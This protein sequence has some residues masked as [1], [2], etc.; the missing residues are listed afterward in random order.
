MEPVHLRLLGPLVVTVDGVRIDVPG[1]GER[2]LL[3]LLALDAGR[4]VAVQ[5][6]V[7]SLWEDAMPADPTNALQLRV[8]KLRRS[9]GQL[10]VTD[11]SGYR[12]DLPATSIDVHR[13]R[14]LV[15]R[16]RPREALALWQG[17]PLAEFAGSR[18]ADV[19]VTAL[20]QEQVHAITDRIDADLAQGRHRELVGELQRLVEEHPANERLW[21]QL[22]LAQYRC[23]RQATALATF[24]R[25]RDVLADQFGLDPGPRLAQ[26]EGAVLR[27]DPSLAPPEVSPARTPAPLGRLVGRAGELSRVLSA[28][29]THRLVTVVGTGGVGK[30]RLAV[31]AA[32]EVAAAHDDGAVVVHLG[33]VT[34]PT[35]VAAAVAAAAGTDPRGGSDDRDLLAAWFQR[36]D[37]V[38]VLDGCE[39]VIAAT[40]DLVGDLLAAAP[41]LSVL[42]TSRVSLGIA[43]GTDVSLG[44]LSR[45]A[46]V[47]LFLERASEV[48]GGAGALDGQD[49]GG[50]AV[51]TVVDRVDRLP[52]AIELAAAWTR[53]LPVEEI[54]RRLDAD[55]ALL[56]HA[57]G[58]DGARRPLHDVV[59]RSLDLLSTPE[60]ALF[61]RL[62]VLVGSWSLEDAEVVCGDGAGDRTVVVLARLVEQS[63]VVARDGRYR[64]LAPLAEVAVARLGA[65]GEES[66][67]RQAH[68]TH[69]L[70]LARVA[71]DRL[72][73]REQARWLAR[74]RA[75]EANMAAALA[76]ARQQA[77]VGT[78]ELLL[79]AAGLGWFWFL[80]RHGDGRRELTAALAAADHGDGAA[81]SARGRALQAQSIVLRPGGCIVHPDDHAHELALASHDLLASVGDERRALLSAV[82]CDVQAVGGVGT[83]A[84]L[85]R[86]AAAA[87]RFSAWGDAWGAAMA[88]FV[89]MEIHVQQG[90]IDDAVL[91]GERARGRF[92]QVTD[93]WGTSSVALHLAHGLRLAGRI[94][95]ATALLEVARDEA[96][97]AGIR[98]TLCGIQVDLARIGL[99][100]GD[101]AATR[102]AVDRV[103]SL[104]EDLGNRMLVGMAEVVEATLQL[105]RDRGDQARRL[106]RAA[107]ARF[108][109]EGVP[110]GLAEALSLC[111]R[112][113]V[114]RGDLG[115]AER[116]A[117]RS[118][119]LSRSMHDRG[120]EA[121]ALETLALAAASRGACTDA[122]TALG[123]AASVRREGGR[124]ACRTEQ[125][126]ADRAAT[127]ARRVLGDQR[128]DALVAAA[129]ATTS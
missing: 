116:H 37:C 89:A 115:A 121:Q 26:L 112:D 27:Q 67:V 80:G 40:A 43:G 78:D 56:D 51:A 109:A 111:A 8:S 108:E 104:A 123:R 126:V 107:I 23:E 122:A 69:F 98:N 61:R 44:P 76:W 4:R 79:A 110:G 17:P 119:D 53:S 45:S 41:R 15:A 59:A 95:H 87:R 9:V 128:F 72:R 54:A 29:A 5:H 114:D 125:V 91:V 118:L 75:S 25:A 93:A 90:D 32:G 73:G 22:M 46:A 33:D 58:P 124:P 103:R 101:A 60:E 70:G 50:P 129:G 21:A 2:A 52:L 117:R 77:G 16:R 18:W 14:E 64:I 85:E 97:G 120:L 48:A 1:R 38:L 55:L 94:D 81:A 68:A 66:M 35:R 113:E 99:H 86:L 7:E 30:T 88:D 19:E 92:E 49:E 11:P 100:R 106:L 24:Q 74:L 82:M 127:L 84:A 47:Q 65:A 12:L 13:F 36:R 71:E 83:T 3:S 31:A 62:G 42:A 105:E 96:E 34:E 63:L 57:A 39:H 28:L 20:R 102:R 10:V 6:L